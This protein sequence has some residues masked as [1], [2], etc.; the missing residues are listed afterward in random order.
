MQLEIITPEDTLFQGEIQGAKFPGLD[1]S[2][3]ILK[4]HAPM[5]SRIEAGQ[6]RVTTA[7]EETQYYTVEDG[8]VEVRDNNVIAL[9]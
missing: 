2:F 7:K 1:G 3:E 6:I 8:F 5:I 9:V 4:G